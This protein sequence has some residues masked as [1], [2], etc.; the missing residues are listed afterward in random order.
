MPGFTCCTDITSPTSMSGERIDIVFVRGGV[1]PQA[2]EI[3][4]VD[5]AKRTAAGLWPSDHAG[6]VATLQVPGGAA[7]T[8]A[9]SA[10][11]GKKY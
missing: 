9:G 11:G 5:P 6:V 7:T 8:T 2:A 3:V 1:T 4:G 10:G